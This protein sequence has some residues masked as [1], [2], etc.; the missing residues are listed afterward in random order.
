M[1]ASCLDVQLFLVLLVLVFGLVTFPASTHTNFPETLWHSRMP[2]TEWAHWPSWVHALPAV[3]VYFFSTVVPEPLKV[4][5]FVFA[6]SLAGK[7]AA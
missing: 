2:F 3:F 1:F 4:E 5:A 7:S 6:N